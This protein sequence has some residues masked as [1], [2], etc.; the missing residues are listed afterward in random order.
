MASTS[1]L[2]DSSEMAGLCANGL[3][4]TILIP[5]DANGF[6]TI[7]SLCLSIKFGLQDMSVWMECEV[8]D[9]VTH[10]VTHTAREVSLIFNDGLTIWKIDLGRFRVYGL[11]VSQMALPT[12]ILTP[13]LS[14]SCTITTF[15]GI[16]LRLSLD[17]NVLLIYKTLRMFLR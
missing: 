12:Q 14:S 7:Y 4:I 3:G 16:R 1:F 10:V 11:T 8:F 15:L 13:R 5:V 2:P 9:P 6:A 17:H